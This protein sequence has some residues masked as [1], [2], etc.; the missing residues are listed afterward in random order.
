L[1][2]LT[3]KSLK[4]FL[5]Q[6]ER[7]DKDL[8]FVLQDVTDPV[9]VGAAFRI[10]DACGVRELVLTGLSP[11][12][13][14]ATIA[15]IGRGTHRHVKWRYVKQA[16]DILA[17]LKAQGYTSC[18]VEVTGESLPYFRATYPEKL[19]LLVGNEHHGV[20]R[21]TLSGCDLSVY[22]PMYGKIRSLNVHV[23]LAI[24]AFHVLHGQQGR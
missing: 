17:E 19:C 18:A 7:H 13:P 9:N 11:A 21:R 22:V 6:G 12:P 15:G 23:A 10:A 4:D 5:K 3:G 1:K 20:A 14:N 24:V 2:Q 16:I 8:V